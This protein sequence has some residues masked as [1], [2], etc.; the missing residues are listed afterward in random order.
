MDKNEEVVECIN[1]E[2]H[3]DGKVGGIPS[4]RNYRYFVNREMSKRYLDALNDQGFTGFDKRAF[5]SISDPGFTGFD[6]RFQDHLTTESE[7]QKRALDALT[8]GGFT[9]FDKRALVYVR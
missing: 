5:D 4:L 1:S 3:V 7:M 9:G 6:K 8:D 2:E